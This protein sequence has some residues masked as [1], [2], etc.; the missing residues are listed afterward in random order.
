MNCKHWFLLSALAAISHA[1]A[2]KQFTQQDTLRGSIGPGRIWWDVASYDLS[3][4]IDPAHKTISGSNTITYRPTAEGTWMQIDL[5]EPLVIDSIQQKGVLLPFQRMGNAYRVDGLITSP[6]SQPHELTVYY[7]GSPRTA[8]RAPWDGGFSWDIDQNGTPFIATSCQG[9]GAS[10]WW[11]NKDHM[12]DEA[13][14][15]KIS[16]TVPE[17]LKDVSNGQLIDELTDSGWSTYVWQVTNPINNYG[18]N[19]NIGS[20]VHFGE[21]YSGE[22]GPLKMDYYVLPED[23]PAAKNQF[24]QAAQ[25]ME[26]LEYWLGPYPFYEDGFK[27]VQVPYLGME[28]QSSV[29]YGNGFENGYRGTDLSGTGWGLTF[30]FIIIHESAHEWF[31]NNITYRDSA[32]MWVHEGFTAYSESLYLDYYYGPEAASEYIRGTRKR[33]QNDV[34]IIAPYGVNATG[35]GDMYYKGAN[36]LQMIRRMV[37]HD[38][39]WREILR[40]MNREFYHQTVTTQQIES[41]LIRETGLELAPIFDQY[42]RD[43]RI[44]VLATKQT[45]EGVAVRF[46]NTIQGFKMPIHLSG[47]QSEIEVVVSETWQI[48]P[49]LKNY[50]S[51]SWHPDYYIN[52]IQ[53]N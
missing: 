35:S 34:P 36:M 53:V 16:V 21:I 15:M 42:L 14:K 27:L 9:L 28:H 2:Q 32:D 1:Q 7:H 11:P 52:S 19:I 48:V 44:P 40:N 46:E 5:Q 12:Y 43:V 10:V 50:K 4:K 20:Y 29:T 41:F 6:L 37:N 30:D 39:H 26:A 51:I 31:A 13:E 17:G 33:I 49:E 25:M 47:E 3:V 18:V 8:V 38:A 22:S 45:P 24:K 23:L